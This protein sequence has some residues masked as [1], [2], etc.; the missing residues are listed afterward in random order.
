MATPVG[1]ARHTAV[2]SA[3]DPRR[4]W[5]LGAVATG[6]LMIGID[7]TIVNIALP[8]VQ[9]SLGL[10]DPA[11]QWVITSY[12]LAYGGLLL[13]GGRLSDLIGRR[14]SLMIGLTGFL[15]VLTIAGLIQGQAW[16]NGEMVVRTL[17]E[18]TPY[19][20]LRAAF[21]VAILSGALIGLYNFVMTVYQGDP[22]MPEYITQPEVG[23]L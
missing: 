12:A 20:G 22:F 4:W 19:M 21:G 14:R 1:S 16:Y 17:T 5:A 23:I 3:P 6:Q 13:L 15:A 11:R 10:S 9:R 18:I 7:L 2:P 8:S